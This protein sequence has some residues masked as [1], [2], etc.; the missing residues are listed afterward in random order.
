VII[1]DTT[2]RDGEQS[3]GA[4]M[5]IGEKAGNRAS[6]VD[7]GVDVMK[8]VSDRVA[9]RFR[10]RSRCFGG[11][12][13][14]RPSADWPD[15]MIRISI[16]PGGFAK[17]ASKD[18]CISGYQPPFHREFKLRMNQDEIIRRAVDSVRR[19]KSY[20]ENVESSPEDAAR[21]EL[22]FLTAV[23][24]AAIEAGATTV[25]IPVYGRYATHS[26]MRA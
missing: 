18:S 2:L 12:Q 8:Q 15:A 4:S 26:T 24:Q 9:G 23:V 16:G 11:M 20:C 17:A 19:A 22:D 6:L 7:L 3:P 1:F 10:G 13:G 21:T 14:A 25:N 5:N